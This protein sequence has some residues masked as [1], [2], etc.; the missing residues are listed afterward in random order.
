MQRNERGNISVWNHQFQG[1]PDTT[2][3]LLGFL[4]PCERQCHVSKVVTEDEEFVL[5][6][7]LT[8]F[9]GYVVRLS[10]RLTGECRVLTGGLHSGLMGDVCG[11]ALKSSPSRLLEP[12]PVILFS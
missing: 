1:R 9:S 8:L 2:L 11:P 4:S 3:C 5:T 12:L 6:E 7:F 10:S